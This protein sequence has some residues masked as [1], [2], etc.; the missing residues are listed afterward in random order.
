MQDVLSGPQHPIPHTA[1]R[2]KTAPIIKDTSGCREP[3]PAAE[4]YN[5]KFSLHISLFEGLRV[6]NSDNY[7]PKFKHTLVMC[8]K[9]SEGLNVPPQSNLIINR[10]KAMFL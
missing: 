10:S 4:A 1:I 8:V 6:L 3:A 5:F 2:S 9:S 7:N